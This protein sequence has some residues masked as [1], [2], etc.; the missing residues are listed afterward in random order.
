MDT[1]VNRTHQ[2][3]RVNNL[4]NSEFTD[5][6]RVN[7]AAAAR[8]SEREY[9]TTPWYRERIANDAEV[10]TRHVQLNPLGHTHTRKW[11][12]TSRT[13]YNL[14]HH[15]HV[16]V[17]KSWD[18]K[19][20]KIATN[21]CACTLTIHGNESSRGEWGPAYSTLATPLKTPASRDWRLSL[22]AH[23]SLAGAL[24]WLGRFISHTATCWVFQS[25]NTKQVLLVTIICTYQKVNVH[26]FFKHLSQTLQQLLTDLLNWV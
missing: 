23:L 19:Q 3:C 25:I 22:I 12:N 9:Q 20:W 7:A 26:V 6:Y 24:C 15:H 11:S 21:K 1:N 4:D 8:H 16:G 13:S 5:S 10:N 14:D 18:H 2:S 17:R